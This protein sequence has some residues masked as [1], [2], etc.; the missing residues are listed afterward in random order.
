VS[1]LPP[2]SLPPSSA[3]TPSLLPR[4]GNLLL[5]TPSLEDPNFHRSVILLLA[6]GQEEGALGVVLNRANDVPVGILL[7]G[8]EDV[9]SEPA[10]VFVGGPV[11]R[12]AVICVARL[13]PDVADGFDGC[14]PVAGRIATIDLNRPA[15]EMAPGVDRV[16][17]FSGYAGWSA[18]QLDEELESGSWFVL[19]S[20]LDDPFTSE[21][22]GLWERIL[23][24]Q[25]GRYA[26]YAKAPPKLSMN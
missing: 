2:P 8:W 11:Q 17:I 22:D 18:G 7:P 14:Q 26:L 21:P 20:E 19:P 13:R 16:R 15:Q 5:A 6:Y 10:S 23:L 4:A 24:R 9:V 25:G 12:S 1:P 3:P